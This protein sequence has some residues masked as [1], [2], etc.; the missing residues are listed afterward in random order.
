MGYE[1][2]GAFITFI[3]LPIVIGCFIVFW[4]MT[5]QARDE[6]EGFFRSLAAR[7]DREFCPAEGEWPNRTSASVMWTNGDVRFRL[8]SVG[9]EGGAKTRLVVWP[10]SK[11]LGTLVVSATSGGGRFENSFSV[12]ARP[13]GFGAR[14]LDDRAKKALLAFRQGDDVRVAYRR[15]RLVLVWPGR[16]TNEARID[17]AERVLVELVRAIDASFVHATKAA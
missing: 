11:L 16:E 13:R 2:L 4:R 6:L 3:L 17:E 1:L 9:K 5:N 10:R 8:D 12:H 15:G 14:I 7:R